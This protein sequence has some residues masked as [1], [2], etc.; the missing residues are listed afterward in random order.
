M[1]ATVPPAWNAFEWYR[2]AIE[3]NDVKPWHSRASK[4]DDSALDKAA[5]RVGE[6]WSLV[7]PLARWLMADGLAQDVGTTRIES[8]EDRAAARALIRGIAESVDGRGPQL[9]L[10]EMSEQYFSREEDHLS[11]AGLPSPLWPIRAWSSLE[12]LIE[13]AVAAIEEEFLRSSGDPQ[14]LLVDEY[15]CVELR[16][17]RDTHEFLMSRRGSDWFIVFWPSIWRSLPGLLPP[18]PSGPGGDPAGVREASGPRPP[19]ASGGAA[20]PLPED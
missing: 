1:D 3:L 17:G 11:T 15:Q 9:A 6:M 18:Q 5:K 16:S 12:P 7:D 19:H 2:L 10:V 13:R 4:L 14:L 20:L 8:S